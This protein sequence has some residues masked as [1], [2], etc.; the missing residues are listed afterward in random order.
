MGRERRLNVVNGPP[1][2]FTIFDSLFDGAFR[3]CD[4]ELVSC[5]AASER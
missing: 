2:A 1:K 3:R 4:D 5:I